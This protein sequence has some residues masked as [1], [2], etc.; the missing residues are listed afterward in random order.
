MT[1]W[2]FTMKTMND[3]WWMMNGMNWNEMNDGDDMMTI[4]HEDWRQ[5]MNDEWDELK[6]MKMKMT[7][8]TTMHSRAGNQIEGGLSVMTMSHHKLTKVT[9]DVLW[10]VWCLRKWSIEHPRFDFWL[11]CEVEPEIKARALSV[12]MMSDG[13]E[14]RMHRWIIPRSIGFPARL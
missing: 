9:C 1:W 11:D 13:N 3:E 12:M 6:E 14:W 2:R 10:I 8:Q 7:M 4:Y 5:W